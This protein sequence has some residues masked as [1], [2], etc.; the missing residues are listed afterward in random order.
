ARH[1]V[2][3]AIRIAMERRSVTCIIV[4][5]DVQDLPAVPTP[6][7]KHG[8]VR[9]GIG[10][11]AHAHVPEST[12]LQNAAEVLNSGDRVAILAGAGALHATDE[13]MQVA[14]LLGAGVAKALL[15]KAA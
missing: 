6:P 10:Y 4:P 15:G 7:H 13:I 5:N 9:T 2:D 12:G 14:D 8:T 1:L 11:T 3:R